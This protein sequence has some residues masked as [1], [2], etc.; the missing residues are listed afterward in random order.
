MEVLGGASHP[1]GKGL[2]AFHHDAFADLMDVH[3]EPHVRVALGTIIGPAKVIDPLGPA[4]GIILGKLLGVAAFIHGI[5]LT[6]VLAHDREDRHITGAVSDVD[7]VLDGDAAVLP[8]DLGVDVD[9][10]VFVRPFV[11]LKDKARLDRVIDDPANLGHLSVFL[12]GKH[13]RLLLK[14]RPKGAFEKLAP[15]NV[16]DEGRDGTPPNHLTQAGRDNVMLQ[17][18]V[19]LAK[20]RIILDVVPHRPKKL[21]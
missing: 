2:L 1:A 12:R 8:V 6:P 3:L 14:I 18:N 10:R 20:D 17:N 13:L 5:G 15:V 16:L 4:E 11:N 7:H 9:G 19:I 21:R